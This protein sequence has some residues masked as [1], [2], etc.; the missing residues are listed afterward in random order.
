MYKILKYASTILIS[1]RKL[2]FP[3][4]THVG[5]H[6]TSLPSLATL[7]SLSLLMFKATIKIFQNVKPDVALTVEQGLPLTA[8]H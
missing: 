4:M 8:E 7:M 6:P 1:L 2:W 5:R 3:K